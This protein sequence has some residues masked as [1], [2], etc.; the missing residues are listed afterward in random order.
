MISRKAGSQQISYTANGN[1]TSMPG[2]G[3]LAYENSAKP[4]QVTLLTPTG[5]AVP[6]REQ[7]VT[8]TS[9]QRPATITEDGITA[10]FAYNSAG[11]RVKMEVKQGAT[12][13]LTRYYLGK[14]YELDVQTNTQRLYLGGDAYSAPALYVKEGTG[15]WKIYYILRDY[16][17]RIRLILN[18]DGSLKQALSDAAWGR[19]GNPGTQTGYTP[20]SEPALFSG[21]G[22]TGH[23]YLPWFGLV[24]MN[25]RLYDPALG[26]FLSPDPYVQ[27]PDFTQ[28]LNRYSYAL[29]NPLVYVDENGEFIHLVLGAII[30]GTVN[31]VSNWKNID[32]NFWKGLG[33]FGV[34]AAAGTL[35]AGIG[36]GVNV[37]MA[38][39]GFGAG[40]MGTAAGVSACGFV[41]G[42]GTRG[43]G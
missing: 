11:D 18:S 36:A 15:S 13:L 2:V 41:E 38:G 29:N 16:L 23:E 21:R 31:L 22:Y 6:I 40:F 10:S 12:D 9:Y 7:S 19:L 3:T 8:Y 14:Q 25:A 30:G 35:S 39:G 17:G 1:I 5:A 43:V 28:N 24:N 34:G 26:R 4:Y 33:Y 20:G 37:A 32:G 42:G 27:M